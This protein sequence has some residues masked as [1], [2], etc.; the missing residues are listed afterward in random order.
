MKKNTKPS[1]NIIKKVKLPYKD[2]QF[3]VVIEMSGG[4]R[5]K[6]MCEDGKTRM[7]RIGGRFKKRMWVRV[8][9]LI[10]IKPWPIQADIKADLVY[11]YLPTQR[12]WI[13]N[14]DI[15]P[16]ELNIW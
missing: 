16:E 15:I 6:A 10:L 11:R 12:N 3:A 8:N 13:L 5:L 9:D 1:E 4:S 7:V 2:E 14:R